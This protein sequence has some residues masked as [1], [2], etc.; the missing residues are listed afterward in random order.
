MVRESAKTNQ[1]K[2]RTLKRIFYF[3]P[4]YPKSQEGKRTPQQKENF[5][6]ILFPCEKRIDKVKTGVPS[7]LDVAGENHIGRRTRCFDVAA[8][9]VDDR[10]IA[11]KPNATMKAMLF[12]K[13]KDLSLS[14]IAAQYNTNKEK[15]RKIVN[16]TVTT[17]RG[18]AK[19]LNLKKGP[20]IKKKKKS[21]Q[22]IPTVE[23]QGKSQT[24]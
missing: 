1:K 4:K 3:T 8:H 16:G 14:Q 23:V 5:C 6:C 2:K 12:Q 21:L 9:G 18:F 13:K 19:L 11:T 20:P 24:R 22:S 15:I 10:T 17:T 7:M